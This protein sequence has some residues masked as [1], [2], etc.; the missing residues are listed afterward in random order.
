MSDFASS[1][2]GVTEAIAA[3]STGG[4]HGSVFKIGINGERSA[5]LDYTNRLSST[6]AVLVRSSSIA[7]LTLT[8]PPR[9]A[10]RYS[11]GLKEV[12]KTS[13]RKDVVKCVS[14]FDIVETCI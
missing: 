9:R 6:I 11:R 5:I 14:G 4:H 3:S 12:S 10:S 2:I 8:H 13:N 7:T 1:R